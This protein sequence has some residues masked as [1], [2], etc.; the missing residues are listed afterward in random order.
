VH[1]RRDFAVV[2]LVS[3]LLLAPCFWHSRIQAGDLSSHAYNAWLA[4]QVEHGNGHGLF[5]ENPWTN[6]LFDLMLAGLAKA[7]GVAAAQRIAVSTAVLIFFWGSFALVSAVARKRPWFLTPCLAILAYGWTF[8]M[9]LFN[10]YLSAG[11]SMW[12]LFFASKRGTVF[13][14]AALA[15]V[16][17]AA[18]AHTLPVFWAVGAGA[19]AW[20][21][22]RAPRRIRILMPILALSAIAAA[23]FA[24]MKLF[25]C[26]WSI[27]QIFNM[28]A[29]DQAAVFGTKYFSIGFALLGFW[30]I[31]FFRLVQTVGRKAFACAPFHIALFAA[32]AVLLIPTRIQLPEY[33]HVL[34]YVSE[35]SSLLVG[36][37]LCALFGAANPGRLAKVWICITAAVYFSFLYADT[38]ALNDFEDAMQRVVATLPP[39]Q[40]VVCSVRPYHSRVNAL[41]HVVDRVC[42]G[43]CFSYANY[44]LSTGQFRLRARDDSSIV[45]T[46]YDD[47]YA[48]QIG[49]YVV[50]ERDLPLHQIYLAGDK[51]TD[52]R[53]KLLNAGELSGA[54]WWE[55]APFL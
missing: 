39:G 1:F 51:P 35:R 31:L 7:A 24:L 36:I 33:K 49:S 30:I 54:T 2:V 8:H 40:R 29:A 19:Y 22:P 44:E 37:C 16:V 55:S 5:I 4:L 25:A 21:W 13:P 3:T 10:F 27:I 47:S 38:R 23:R 32:A 53:V 45:V 20:L 15:L 26:D 17:L 42:I 46:N 50:K 11:L 48:L 28:V 34:G 14:I 43:R 18:F 6:V 9:G 52:L 41:A 12:A